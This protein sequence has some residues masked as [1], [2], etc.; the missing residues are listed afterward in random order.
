MDLKQRLGPLPIW[1]WGGI[2]GATVGI[3]WRLLDRRRTPS[4]AEDGVS[5][6]DVDP[7]DG[8]AN[9]SG[10]GSA[11]YV[12]GITNPA[13]GI[14]QSVAQTP[15]NP[16]TG[17]PYAVDVMMPINPET[18]QP[19]QVDVALGAQ[20]SRYLQSQV[21]RLASERE[22]LLNQVAVAPAPP[23]VVAPAPPPP[24]TVAPSPAPR[25]TATPAKGTHVW[26]GSTKPNMNTIRGLLQ[27]RY[28]NPGIRTRTTRAGTGQY[29][30]TIA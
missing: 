2:A 6:A 24:V 19:Y 3:G 9:T 18:G 22:Q 27:A 13:T 5:T 8:L 20:E 15:I 21:D 29:V 14:D 7:D 11:P 16:Q 1:A 26:K 4:D 23:P 10:W 28:G 12:S 30:V 17:N 25:P